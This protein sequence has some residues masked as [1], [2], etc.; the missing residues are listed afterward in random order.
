MTELSQKCSFLVFIG[1]MENR[2]YAEEDLLREENVENRG[3]DFL[4]TL[5]FPRDVVLQSC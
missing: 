4:E 3:T 1:W 2:T 5:E